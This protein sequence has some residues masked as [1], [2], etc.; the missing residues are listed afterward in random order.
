MRN[1]VRKA[2]CER[3]VSWLRLLEIQR[4]TL[5][6][7]GPLYNFSTPCLKP[8]KKGLGQRFGSGPV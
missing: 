8:E 2:S 5:T 1:S 4:R 7:K 3:E 6:V